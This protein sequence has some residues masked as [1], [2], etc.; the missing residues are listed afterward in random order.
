MYEREYCYCNFNSYLSHRIIEIFLA[1]IKKYYEPK[2]TGIHFRI[3]L[4]SIRKKLSAVHDFSVLI[5]RI[6]IGFKAI[7]E[8]FQTFLPLKKRYKGDSIWVLIKLIISF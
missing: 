7:L 4:F 6:S 8:K 1:D 3:F 2:K 5:Q